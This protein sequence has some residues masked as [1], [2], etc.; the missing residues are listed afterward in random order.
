MVV[1]KSSNNG[2]YD[3][4][5]NLENVQFKFDESTKVQGL[6]KDYNLVGSKI[7]SRLDFFLQWS[8]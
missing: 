4:D 6:R 8:F 3:M 1:T 5:K 2:I 7:E